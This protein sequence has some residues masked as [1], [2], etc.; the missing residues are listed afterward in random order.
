[1]HHDSI[2]SFVVLQN[3]RYDGQ[4]GVVGWQLQQQ[5]ADL[6]VFL[7]GAGALGCEFLKNFALMGIGTGPKGQVRLYDHWAD[8][9]IR[10]PPEAATCQ[11]C[12][13]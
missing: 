10:I 2:G 8:C 5:L 6:K 12:C 9:G 1:M 4:A 7:V 11:A 13:T 3:N